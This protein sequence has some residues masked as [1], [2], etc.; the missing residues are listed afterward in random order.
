MS[1]LH[2][3]YDAYVAMLEKIKFSA[4]DTLYVL[5]DVINRGPD[6]VPI[7][8]D[9]MERDNVV[10]L[11]GNH[12]LM[13]LNPFEHLSL[14]EYDH[15]L[16]SEVIMEVTEYTR[17]PFDSQTLFDFA[18]LPLAEKKSLNEYLQG[19]PLYLE[20][21]IGGQK[22]I[23]AHAGLNVD[24][25]EYSSAEIEEGIPQ[26]A[27]EKSGSEAVFIYGDKAY[28]ASRESLVWSRHDYNKEFFPDVKIITG[29]IV[30]RQVDPNSDGGIVRMNNNIAIDCGMGFRDG[31]LACLCL[32]TGEEFY[33]E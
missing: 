23:M 30:T 14:M 8:L 17:I 26:W 25:R 10:L 4:D 3:N 21:E 31:K 2:G 24:A 1:D 16:D 7:L 5:G 9:I 11:M 12:E 32:E 18:R 27:R 19:L 6:G 29:H 15:N 28:S 20:T 13:N 22:Y 33:T